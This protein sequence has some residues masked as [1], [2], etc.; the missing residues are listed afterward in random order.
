MKKALLILPML[1]VAG[2]FFWQEDTVR[3]DPGVLAPDPPQQQKLQSAQPFTHKG[4]T[5]TPLATFAATA[6]VLS[7]KR[8]RWGREADLSPLDLA[9]GWG[10]MSDQQVLEDIEI[11]QA[12]R[13]YRWR[14]KRFPI[15]RREIEL[16]SSNMHLIP[17]NPAVAEMMTAVRRG[18]IV[19]FQGFLVRVDG[20]D[21]WRWV[22]SLTRRDTGARACELVWVEAF[23]ILEY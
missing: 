8:Y 20:E 2:Y 21:R 15:P 9:L 5:I 12:N 16:Y 10:R 4:Y 1:A 23:T 13:W 3:L 14:T 19:S 7:V 22:S 17:A 18:E 6:K 11:W